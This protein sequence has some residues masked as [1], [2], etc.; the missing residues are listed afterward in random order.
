MG[1]LKLQRWLALGSL[2]LAGCGRANSSVPA[3]VQPV[4]QSSHVVSGR[5]TYNGEPVRYGFVLA[6]SKAGVDPKTGST[7]PPKVAAIDESGRYEIPN[8]IVGPCVLCVATDPDLDPGTLILSGSAVTKPV[9]GPPAMPIPGAPP[10]MP[11]QPTMPPGMPGRPPGMPAGM[12]PMLP[13]APPVP[14]GAPPMPGPPPLPVSPV[15]ERMT[16]Q[17][18]AVLKEIHVKYG[19][20]HESPLGF[21]VA[22][23]ADQTFDIVLKATPATANRP[24]MKPTV[25][26]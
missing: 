24:K 8:P 19:N 18:K 9:G 11:G 1:R 15:L 26:N 14:P 2:A 5:V 4:R 25:A 16:A 13:G 3:P 6:Y 21:V 12:P 17:Q 23:N 22:G 7:A 20:L 10:M